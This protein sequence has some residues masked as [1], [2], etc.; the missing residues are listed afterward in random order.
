MKILNVQEM[1]ELNA[2]LYLFSREVT[3]EGQR[4][5]FIENPNIFYEYYIQ[6][7]DQLKT[8]YDVL[9]SGKPCRLFFDIEY[10]K[11]LNHQVAGETRMTV[12]RKV[13]RDALNELMLQAGKGGVTASP[14]HATISATE[15]DASNK[16]KFSR[17]VIVTLDSFAFR[18][19]THAGFFV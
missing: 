1:V 6:I 8:V 3:T 14:H 18:D 10:K 16:I 11:I 2:Q 13:L 19:I 5:F 12:F 9:L 4:Y 7:P 15:L 17:H